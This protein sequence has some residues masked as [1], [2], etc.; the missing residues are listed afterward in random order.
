MNDLHQS[1]Q[2]SLTS[3]CRF[4]IMCSLILSHPPCRRVLKLMCDSPVEFLLL[5]V[6]CVYYHIILVRL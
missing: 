2:L 1:Y 3:G 6:D 5:F 4:M